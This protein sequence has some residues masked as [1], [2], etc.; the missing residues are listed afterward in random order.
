[1]DLR[2]HREHQARLDLVEGLK[3]YVA[4]HVMPTLRRDFEKWCD[5]EH[6]TDAQ[7]RDTKYMHAKFDNDPL[8]QA[9]RGLQRISQESIDRKSVV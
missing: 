1:M 6:P 7:L 5:E 9:S 8:Y 2:I 3:V 4:G